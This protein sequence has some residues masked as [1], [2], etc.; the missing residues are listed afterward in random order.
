MRFGSK[1]FD[2][3]NVGL[4]RNYQRKGLLNNL[5]SDV[6]NIH[7]HSQSDTFK[8]KSLV[9]GLSATRLFLHELIHVTQTIAVV[10]CI[11]KE[12]RVVSI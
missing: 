7:P 5:L 1:T 9:F 3:E 8:A 11:T 2:F 12:F 10:N 6:Q 4:K